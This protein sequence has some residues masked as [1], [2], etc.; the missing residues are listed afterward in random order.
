MSKVCLIVD[1]TDWSVCLT[2]CDMIHMN[3]HTHLRL[4][5]EE[6]LRTSYVPGVQNLNRIKLF[7]FDHLLE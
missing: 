1:L 2:V 6:P 3:A 4:I 5:V 7:R